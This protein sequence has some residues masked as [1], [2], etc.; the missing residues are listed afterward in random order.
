[1]K[2]IR[3]QLQGG[4][5]NQLFIWAMAHEL[6]L[7]A[8]ARIKIVYV[9]DG[10]QR[11]DRPPELSNLIS[12]CDHPIS[13]HQSKIL[14]LL[15]RTID[16]LSIRSQFMSTI[17]SNTF[18][19]YTCQT[20]DEVPDFTIRHPRILRGFFQDINM[21]DNNGQILRA[22]IEKTL[23]SLPDTST[24]EGAVVLHIRRGDTRVISKSW[25]V[26]TD[27]YYLRIVE[28]SKKVVICTDD[29]TEKENLIR[30]FPDAKILTPMNTSTWETLKILASAK[31]LVMA[32][33]TLS[34]WAAWLSSDQRGIKVYFPTPWRPNKENAFEKL[35]IPGL[36][37]TVADYE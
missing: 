32:N 34:W 29:L 5:G 2:T 20:T 18:G 33:S 26:L 19:V 11:L 35:V 37:Y 8:G 4:L 36:I 31:E 10:I 16:K 25:G 13:L 6:A 23:Q 7:A 9:N 24:S 3:L 15:F 1:M 14:G 12:H 17:I 27:K 21:I 22:E 28:N 30:N